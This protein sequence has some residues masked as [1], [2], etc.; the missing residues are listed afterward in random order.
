VAEKIA[1]KPLRGNPPLFVEDDSNLR[2]YRTEL[3][4]IVFLLGLTPY[5]LALYVLLKKT[6]GTDGVCWKSTQT[7]ADE[8]KMSVGMVSK[9]KSAL[10]KA[11]KILK[12]KSLIFIKSIP[13]PRGGKPYQH[14][15]LT[16]IWPENMAFFSKATSSHERASSPD[17]I[18]TSPGEIKKEPREE[19][20]P[21]ESNSARPSGSRTA[22]A[23]TDLHS[24]PLAVQA[25]SDH[26]A[27]MAYL[28]ERCGPIPNPAAQG[29]ALKWLL[30]F[31]PLDQCCSCLDAL[32]GDDWRKTAV[33]WQ[34]VQKEIGT[35]LARKEKSDAGNGRP[36]ASGRRDHA[37]AGGRQ[38]SRIDRDRDEY[39][40]QNRDVSFIGSPSALDG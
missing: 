22:R 40:R 11:K 28:Q 15:T 10:A 36:Q 39:L 23:V 35:W 8:T 4:N 21:E 5:E 17:E 1:P 13:N 18:A 37:E 9:A 12:G 30:N 24:P 25:G 29:K 31:Y 14:I 33:S 16:D 20:T 7:L 38:P 27:G 2:K 34:T 19:R 32:L 3:P 26:R 6:T